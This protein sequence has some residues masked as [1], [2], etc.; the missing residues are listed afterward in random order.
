MFYG[1]PLGQVL[2]INIYPILRNNNSIIK[3]DARTHAKLSKPNPTDI[4]IPFLD[5]KLSSR[6]QLSNP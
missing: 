5:F 2:S 4:N 6:G 1:V 3:T